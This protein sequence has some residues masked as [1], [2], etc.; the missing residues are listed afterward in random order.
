MKLSKLLKL[1]D[2]SRVLAV[3]LVSISEMGKIIA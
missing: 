1:T 3:V 2:M